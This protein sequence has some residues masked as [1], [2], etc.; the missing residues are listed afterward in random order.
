MTVVSASAPGKIV[1]CGEYAVLHGA[2]AIV[3]AVDCRAVVEV[4]FADGRECLVHS[5]GMDE[6]T[7]RFRRPA[8]GQYRWSTGRYRL[9]E[10]VI[11]A[12]DIE[13]LPTMRLTL[14][15]QSF[16]DRDSGRKF[17]FGSS[18]ALAT[19][20]SAA[21]DTLLEKRADVHTVAARAHRAF[22][23]GKGSGV[24][25]AASFAGG[26]QRFETAGQYRLRELRWPA[27][28]DYRVLWSGCPSSTTRKLRRLPK[29]HKDDDASI[30]IQTAAKRV[31]DVWESGSVDDVLGA[32]SKFVA[33]LQ[34]YSGVH[35][36]GVF[37]A[38]HQEL[39]DPAV[40]RGLVYKPCGAGGGDVGVAFG[41]DAKELNAF[42]DFAGGK[43]F[44]PVNIALAARGVALS[45]GKKS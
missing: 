31:A 37:E 35:N 17:G 27:G 13:T 9:V 23:S 22:Q 21:L 36:I 25:I 41:T 28:L 7:V 43:G 19:A 3:T 34:Q 8:P 15:T 4:A 5:P 38:G 6:E 11:E 16:R 45:L 10:E 32:L 12:L 30:A 14:D 26:T 33:H 42:C 24:D 40:S 18:A 2:P 44:T 20:L 29:N 1:L 39:L